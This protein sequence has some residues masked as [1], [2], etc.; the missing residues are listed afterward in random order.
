[1]G[2]ASDNQTTELNRYVSR[3]IEPFGLRLGQEVAWRVRPEDFTPPQQTPAA[4]AFFGG[5]G[6]SEAGLNDLLL[7]GVPI[8]PIASAEGCISAELPM[9]LRAL[10]CL[11]YTGDG[12]ERIAT[13]MLECVGLLPRQR[14]VFVS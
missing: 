2:A 10:N 8:L 4:V 6:V 7:R 12:F 3:V 14:R 11:T 5:V 13:A 1:M 9:Q